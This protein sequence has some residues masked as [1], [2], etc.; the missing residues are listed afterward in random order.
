MG[1]RTVGLQDTEDLVTSDETHLWD[2]VRVTEGYTDLGGGKTL[3]RQL[4]DVLDDIL[5]SRLE[6]G[7]GSAAVGES[8]GRWTQRLETLPSIC[9]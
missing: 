8:G 5:W 4:G 3:P 9:V 6:P 7:R 2:T 1:R